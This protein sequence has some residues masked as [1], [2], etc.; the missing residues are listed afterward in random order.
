LKRYVHV[1]GDHA[2]PNSNTI[3]DGTNRVIDCR[4]FAAGVRAVN[5]LR[6]LEDAEAA[7][8]LRTRSL[9]SEMHRIA[10]RQ[11]PWQRGYF[12][13]TQFYRYAFIYG[14]GECASYFE[15]SYGLTANQFSLIGFALHAAFR[16]HACIG[17][18][19]SLEEVGITPALMRAALKLLCVPMGDARQSA[20]QMMNEANAGRALE[21]PIVYQP[22]FLRRFPIVSFGNGERLRSPLAQLILLRVT[23]G[24]Y[25]DLV[26]G[27]GN[28]RNEAAD[29]FES[30]CLAYIS[31]TMPE[32][33]PSRSYR[34]GPSGSSF[35]T[36]DILI[37]DAGRL[38]LAIEC[39][40]TKLTFAAQFSDD[41]MVEAQRQYEEIAK[42]VFQLWRYFSHVR[43]GLTP[44]APAEAGLAGMVLTLDTWLTMSKELQEEVFATATE[45]A[46]GDP[47]ITLEDRRRIVFC[48]IEDLESTLL[49]SDK[50]RFLRALSAATEDRFV[51]WQLPQIHRE[52]VGVVQDRKRFPFDLGKVLPWWEESEAILRKREKHA[53]T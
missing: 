40:A 19:N 16:E 24:V 13:I 49:V 14:Q 2:T 39:K 25:Y 27:R 52:S 45:L 32:L 26:S 33:S 8:A 50:A 21:L 10:Q 34:Y 42:G 22:S 31:A 12:N 35:E 15:R 11:F 47:E 37:R 18:G 1:T 3:R 51:G 6:A 41:P 30:Y 46:T 28:L 44:E 36:P 53:E 48:S 38:V 23:A 17:T 9:L 29:R 4:Q 5:Q 20:T 43:R 7:I